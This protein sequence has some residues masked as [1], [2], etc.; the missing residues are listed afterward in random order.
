MDACACAE[1]RLRVKLLNPEALDRKKLEESG[2]CGVMQFSEGIVHLLTG[3]G[4]QQ[5]EIELKALIC[6]ES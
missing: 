6:S 3:P 4:S 2:I 5:Y 1:T